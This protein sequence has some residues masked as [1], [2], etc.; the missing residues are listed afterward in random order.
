MQSLDHLLQNC[1]RL[2]SGLSEGKPGLS[3]ETHIM[4]LLT[5]LQSLVTTFPVN[6]TEELIMAASVFL[7]YSITL[8]LIPA[9]IRS[10]TNIQA[11]HPEKA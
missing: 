6:R 3:I 7:H 2:D 4:V 5:L 9:K 11:N 8:S 10:N 1:L